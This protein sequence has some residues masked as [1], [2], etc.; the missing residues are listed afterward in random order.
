MCTFCLVVPTTL[1]LHCD[2][3]CTCFG[4]LND[5]DDDDDDDD[6]YRQHSA[7]Q[8]AV[9]ITTCSGNSSLSDE[10]NSHGLVQKLH[11]IS[12]HYCIRRPLLLL[13]VI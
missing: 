13:L 5:D 8:L 9:N 1:Q 7:E 11:N 4:E 10:R 2:V 6:A 12:P 3:I